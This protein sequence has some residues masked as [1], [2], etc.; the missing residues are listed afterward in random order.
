MIIILY[1]IYYIIIMYDNYT[2]LELLY[3]LQNKKIPIRCI[4]RKKDIIKMII[5]KRINIPYKY[6]CMKNTLWG[7]YINDSLITNIPNM[8][9]THNTGFQFYQ[10][11]CFH[12][13][14]GTIY[15]I[16]NIIKTPGNHF[17][18]YLY[19]YNNK[20]LEKMNIKY[21]MKLLDYDDVTILQYRHGKKYMSEE[22][23]NFWEKRNNNWITI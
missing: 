7:C 20:I 8:I 2:L 6:E 23:K 4:W 17:I 5:R 3:L 13:S 15:E 14:D 18:I 11:C 21:F 12:F 19:N 10:G 1:N 16:E 9:Y 22:E